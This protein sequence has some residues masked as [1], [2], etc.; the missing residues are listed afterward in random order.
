MSR[1]QSNSLDEQAK[2]IF[3]IPKFSKQRNFLQNKKLL[4]KREIPIASL[5]KN[6]RP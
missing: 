2:R 4:E 3:K 1:Y 5:E 6:E